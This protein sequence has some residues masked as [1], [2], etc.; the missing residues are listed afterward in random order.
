MKNDSGLKQ[1]INYVLSQWNPL[2]VPEF[3]AE[4]EYRSYVEQIISVGN[5][6]KELEVYLVHLV[7]DTLGLEYDENNVE[8]RGDVKKV[9]REMVQAFN[10]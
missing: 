6:E 8:H 1:R 5:N 3:I 9:V 7:R 2:D 10:V 4:D